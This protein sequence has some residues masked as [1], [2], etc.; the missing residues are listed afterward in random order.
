LKPNLKPEMLYTSVYPE[1]VIGKGL[2][3]T[4]K[5]KAWYDKHMSNKGQMRQITA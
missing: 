2:I 4:G 3:L 5:Q 1:P